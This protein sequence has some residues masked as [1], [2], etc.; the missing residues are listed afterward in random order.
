VREPPQADVV[1]SEAGMTVDL[2]TAFGRAS[3]EPVPG[4][5]DQFNQAAENE[6]P[7]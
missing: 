6:K 4:Y 7:I 1:W 2:K 5:R 3:V